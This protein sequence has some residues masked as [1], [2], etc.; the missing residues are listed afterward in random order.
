[1]AANKIAFVCQGN[2]G[3]SQFATALAERERDR[4]GLDVE[5]VTGGVSPGEQVH[6]E[7][8]AALAEEDIDISD[9]IPREI[10][11]TDIVDADYVVTMGCSVDELTPEGWE[12]TVE[13]W[14][15][16]HP[17]TGDIESAREQRDEIH[18]RVERF[19]D[20]ELTD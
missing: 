5:I 4:R 3:R 11:S 12:G 18:T 14:D 17:S 15:L 16:N 13:Q 9:R 6:E 2:A 8:V 10:R 7:V 1:M 19:F 20:R